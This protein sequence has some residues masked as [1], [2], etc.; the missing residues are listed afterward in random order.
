MRRKKKALK[1][2]R[3]IVF[4]FRRLMED[5]GGALALEGRTKIYRTQFYRMARRGNFNVAQLCRIKACFPVDINSYF[6][7]A[8]DDGEHERIGDPS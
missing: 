7:E 1:T 3:T 8:D 6:V 4:D 2:K 5:C